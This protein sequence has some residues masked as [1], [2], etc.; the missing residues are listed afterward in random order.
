MKKIVAK[1][2]TL[3]IAVGLFSNCDQ[4]NMTTQEGQALI[5]K[6]LTLPQKFSESVDGSNYW[7]WNKIMEEGYISDPGNC[8]WGC[9]LR[10]T[11]KGKQ[12]LI[13]E[14]KSGNMFD[15]NFLR[16]V[17]F[18]IDFNQIEGI[19]INKEMHLLHNRPCIRKF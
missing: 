5:V 14:G 17:G 11:A 9:K 13:G 10:P 12:F 19:A 7:K 16:F 18:E 15:Y 4:M 6:N 1:A 3:V 2:V 8:S